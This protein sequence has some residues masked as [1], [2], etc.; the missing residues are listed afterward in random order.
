[1]GTGKG[2]PRHSE[3][4]THPPSHI[5]LVRKTGFER[6]LAGSQLPSTQQSPGPLYFATSEVVS[7]FLSLPIYDTAAQRSASAAE[8]SEVR[9]SPLLGCR[10]LCI[11]TRATSVVA[12]GWILR[13][14]AT[15]CSRAKTMTVPRRAAMVTWHLRNML[16]QGLD[17]S[18]DSGLRYCDRNTRIRPD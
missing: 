16:P 3:D 17:G 15:S 8:R 2:H 7:M 14:M 1:M 6:H 12:N 5:A 11:T 18:P 4:A 9:C 13:H 10:N